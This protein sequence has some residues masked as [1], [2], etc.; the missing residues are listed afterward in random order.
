MGKSVV[1]KDKVVCYLYLN[2]TNDKYVRKL[3]AANGHS[4]SGVIDAIIAAQRNGV[5]L[6]L[7]KIVPK[8]VQKALEHKARKKK[9]LTRA[10]R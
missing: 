2:K 10:G 9:Q 7:V 1:A 5:D 3:A 6:E 8:Y 4:I